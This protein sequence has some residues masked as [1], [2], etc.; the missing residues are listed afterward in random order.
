MKKLLN[1]SMAAVLALV[2]AG[3][4]TG[5]SYEESGIANANSGHRCNSKCTGNSCSKTIY[6]AKDRMSDEVYK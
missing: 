6:T 1:L 4:S 3:C 5:N 2:L